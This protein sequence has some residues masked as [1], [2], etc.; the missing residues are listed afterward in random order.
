MYVALP[1]AKMRQPDAI[2]TVIEHLDLLRQPF[3]EL[4]P[5]VR[6][7]F[8][9]F[10]EEQLI[11]QVRRRTMFGLGPDLILVRDPMALELRRLELSRPATAPADLLHQ[12]DPAAIQRL[13]QPDGQLAGLPLLLQTE[14]A[15]FNRRLLPES[16][17]T[18][19]ALLQASAVGV[20]VGLSL[21]PRELAWLLGGF[22]A[23]DA[24]TAAVRG[25]RPSPQSQ[26]A[27][28]RML[29]WLADANLQKQVSVF[30]SQEPMLQQF[31]AGE[32][33]WIPCHSGDLARLRRHLGGDLGV[34][35]L[36]RGP[37]GEATP[38]N[39]LMVWAFGRNSSARQRDTAERWAR[40]SITPTVQRRFTLQT[41]GNLPVNLLFPV[42]VD[43]SATLRTLETTRQQASRSPVAEVVR[44]MDRNQLALMRRLINDVAFQTMAPG[45]AAE[46]LVKGLIAGAGTGRP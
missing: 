15:C 5:S 27:L 24:I 16:P 44:G 3:L 43:T 31:A 4:H 29:Q 14:Q 23:A 8:I 41:S 40:F 9:P 11:W 1:T 7:Q 36:P 20:P 2:E 25:E 46:R 10:D 30:T 19:G 26:A 17:A 39:T 34:G 45:A 13:R 32:L 12:I 21:A 37:S 18:L 6:I 22:G 42:P 33:A 35:S 38:I 28:V